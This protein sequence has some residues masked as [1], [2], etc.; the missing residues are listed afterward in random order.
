MKR[1]E[2]IADVFEDYHRRVIPKTAGDVQVREC[3]RA[4]HAGAVAVLSLISD[5]VMEGKAAEAVG[6]LYGELRTFPEDVRGGKA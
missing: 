4:F 6:R 3:R 2:T 5:E 1:R